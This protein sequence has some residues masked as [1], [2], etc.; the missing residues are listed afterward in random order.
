MLRFKR[1]KMLQQSIIFK[2]TDLWLSERVV[3]PV[4]MSDLFP[5]P[6]DLALTC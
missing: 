5:Q 2:V 6:I 4:V 3:K 1:L